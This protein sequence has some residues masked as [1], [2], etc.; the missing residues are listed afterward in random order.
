ME[1]V[2]RDY[3]KRIV[4]KIINDNTIVVLPTGS[5][6]TLIAAECV[7]KMKCITLFLVPTCLLVSQQANVFRLYTGLNVVE[8]MVS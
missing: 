8:Y 1:I 7:K 4:D 3:Q 2:L 6:E 5:G